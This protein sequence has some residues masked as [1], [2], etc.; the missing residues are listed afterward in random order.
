MPVLFSRRICFP[1]GFTFLSLCFCFQQILFFSRLCFSAGHASRRP[2]FKQ[3]QLRC[4]YNWFNNTSCLS[5]QVKWNFCSLNFVIPVAQ[6]LQ[7]KKTT[8]FHQAIQI[9]SLLYLIKCHDIITHAHVNSK[10]C[11]PLVKRLRHRPLTAV[12]GVRIPYGSPEK[13]LGKSKVFLF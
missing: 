1:V 12:T 11:G 7:S 2:C 9:I 8:K 6:N 10:C 13:H 5:F 3:V 4:Y